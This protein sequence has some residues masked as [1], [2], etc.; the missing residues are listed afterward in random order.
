[1]ARPKKDPS[2]VKGETIK[3]PL[4]AEQKE[5]ITQAALAV[6]S[7]TAAWARQR[8]VEAAQEQAAKSLKAHGAKSKR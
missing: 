7:D 5:M 4:T 1:M 3:I 2:L 8:L 6:G